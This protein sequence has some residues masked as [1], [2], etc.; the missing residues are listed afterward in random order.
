MIAAAARVGWHVGAAALAAAAVLVT[1]G[2]AARGSG[3]ELGSSASLRVCLDRWNQGRMLAWGPSVAR[4][5]AGPPCTL[6]IAYAYPKNG[7]TGWCPAFRGHPHYCLFLSHTLLCRLN[8]FGAY[9]CQTHADSP[10]LRT[11]NATL[12]RRGHLVLRVRFKGTTPTLPLPW[13][14]KY[15]HT[16]GWIHPWTQSGRLRAGLRLI[17]MLSATCTAISEETITPSALACTSGESILLDP[18]FPRT[19]RWNDGAIALCPTAPGST[20]FIRA[21]V[22]HP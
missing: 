8:I 4:L 11:A 2:L 14:R 18:C 1:P 16:D 9:S 21:R 20:S 15:P 17:G 12:N 13:Q 10:A 7:G 6:R 5:D 19:A 22:R 3:A